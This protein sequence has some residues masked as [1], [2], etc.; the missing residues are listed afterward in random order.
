MQARS[1]APGMDRLRWQRPMNRNK[2]GWLVHIGPNAGHTGFQQWAM[3]LAPPGACLRIRHIG[4][5]T[6][7]RPDRILIIL[8][9]RSLTVQITPL[10]ICVDRVA[11]IDLDASIDN[12]HHMEALSAQL[13]EETSGIREAFPV[14]GKDT[15]ANEGID[16]QIE[17]IARDIARAEGR[18]HLAQLLR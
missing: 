17:R 1:P 15:V 4:K 3:L 6:E 18:C 7:A 5:D 16:I 9:I 2:D 10:P 8:I 14:P 12:T 13:G 11:L